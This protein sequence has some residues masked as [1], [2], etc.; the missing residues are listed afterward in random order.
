MELTIHPIYHFSLVSSFKIRKKMST[1]C[2]QQNILLTTRQ[3]WLFFTVKIHL[4]PGKVYDYFGG[5]NL[6][7]YF[8][9]SIHPFFFQV[10]RSKEASPLVFCKEVRYI[11]SF[12]ILP[13]TEPIE[14]SILGKLHIGC[15]RISGYFNLK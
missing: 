2:V 14:F 11:L 13:T 1:I 7:P 8:Y 12:K 9:P 10:L 4:A 3:I 5:M 6:H 15:G